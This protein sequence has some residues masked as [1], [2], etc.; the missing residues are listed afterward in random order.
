M[1]ESRRLGLRRKKERMRTRTAFEGRKFRNVKK[2]KKREEKMIDRRPYAIMELDGR[3]V[4]RTVG[5]SAEWRR[6]APPA[7]VS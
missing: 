2:G 3:Y 5:A 7:S 1:M 6:V 4:V